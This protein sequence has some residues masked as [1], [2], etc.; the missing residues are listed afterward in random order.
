MKA[1][2]SCPCRA[3]WVLSQHQL[4]KWSSSGREWSCS[5][6]SQGVPTSPPRFSSLFHRSVPGSKHLDRRAL[7]PP[8]STS[9]SFLPT[10]RGAS[11][12]CDLHQG[13][14]ATPLQRSRDQQTSP[15]APRTEPQQFP[16]MG[17]LSGDT[18]KSLVAYGIYSAF[19]N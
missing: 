19:Q 16:E 17:T 7:L 12:S 10:P 9:C 18:L 11:E 1:N 8:T 13:A 6:P 15:S 4:D 5:L 3:P 14:E 2:G